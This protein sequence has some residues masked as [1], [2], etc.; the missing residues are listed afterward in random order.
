MKFC[1]QCA[2]PVDR[3][4]PEGD[5]RERWVCP[6]CGTIHY[7]NPRI[8]AGCIPEWEGRVLLCRRA[9]EPRYGLW[10][11]PAGFMENAETALE[12]AARETL[13]EAR[14]RV[15]VIDLYALF[16]LPHVNQVYMIF[17][18]RLTDLDFGP[19]AETL[20]VRL[21][22]P[23]AIPWR[24]LAFPTI[25]HALRFYFEDRARGSFALRMGDIVR[26]GG[27]ARFQF[28]RGGAG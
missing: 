4:I 3:R 5:N 26:Q 23:E 20:E 7:E 17:R 21:F 14:A 1:S 25:E 11:L 22:E 27:Q 19:G 13:E 2:A 28:R 8:V 6:A 15:E 10:T 24:E 16:N 12:A 9:I 18:S